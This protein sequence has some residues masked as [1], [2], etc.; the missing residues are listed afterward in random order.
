MLD[1]DIC[2]WYTKYI[3]LKEDYMRKLLNIPEGL[4][5]QLKSFAKD[6]G[7]NLSSMIR[8]ILMD[9]IRREKVGK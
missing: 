6:K 3:S 4:H 5:E 1:I 7:L 8:Y 9:Y 2:L